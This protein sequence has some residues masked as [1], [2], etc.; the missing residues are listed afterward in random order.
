MFNNKVQEVELTIEK[1]EHIIKVGAAQ[2]RLITGK[3]RPGDYKLVWLDG[4]IEDGSRNAVIGK[5]SPACQSPE[6]Q[7]AFIKDIDAIGSF[8]QHGNMVIM[9]GQQSAH[10]LESHR[11]TLEEVRAEAIED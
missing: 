7:A 11:E 5:A 4:Y 6:R 2:E 1:A 9:Q 10:A 3:E 8:V